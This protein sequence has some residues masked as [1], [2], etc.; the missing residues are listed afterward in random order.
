M[1]HWHNN[2]WEIMPGSDVLR[3]AAGGAKGWMDGILQV[4]KHLPC[5]LYWQALKAIVRR[6]S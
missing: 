6:R 4:A 5:L 3:I 2:S 1:Y